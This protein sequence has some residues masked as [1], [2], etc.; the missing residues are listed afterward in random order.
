MDVLKAANLALSFFLELCMVVAYG[1]W[2]FTTGS[3]L[4]GQLLLGIGVPL[5]VIIVWGI[6][7]A[8]ASRR[9][10]RGLAHWVLEIILFAGSMVALYVAGRPDL[11]LIFAVIYAINVI[12]RLIWKQ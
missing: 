1:Y 9:R 7:M 5:A 12:L 3:D 10:L 11:A 8:P 6:F 2:G 4:V